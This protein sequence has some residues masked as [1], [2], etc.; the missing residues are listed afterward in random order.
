MQ[1]RKTAEHYLDIV[2]VIILVLDKNKNV[3]EINR[4]GC[5]IIG[6]SYEE[7]IGKNWIEHFIPERLR[8]KVADVGDSLLKPKEN[9]IK[10]FENPILTKEG[11]ERIILW[12]NTTLRDEEGND[13]GILTSGEDVTERRIKDK[14]FMM[15]TRQAQMGE[16]LS[17]IAHQWR[18][19][20]TIINTIAAGLRLDEM[21]KEEQNSALVNSLIQIEE[22]TLHLSQTITDFKDF[23]KPNKPK[24]PTTLVEI[25]K[26]AID[27]VEHSLRSHGIGIEEKVQVNPQLVTYRNEVLQVIM[28]LIK[29][30][31]DAFEEHHSADPK[32]SFTIDTT[33]THALLMVTDNA[34]GIAA[35]IMHDIFL[36]YFTTKDAK[37]GTGL[38]LYMC[39]IVIEEHCGGRLEVSSDHK[40]S[41]TFTISLPL[42]NT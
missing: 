16:M 3:V 39:K 11:Q 4:K 21:F 42:G 29:N 6:Y 25:L 28:T 17:M 30:S 19:P 31:I 35:H 14:L 22:Q 37:H 12:H 41:S 18:Q 1:A 36:P 20:L 10:T 2:D 8:Y 34:G 33:P 9:P 13:V 32:M 27:L 15:Q 26:G 40:T 23:F 5:E 38:G 7:V 24:S